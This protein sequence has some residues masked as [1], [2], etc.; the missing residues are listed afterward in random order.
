[1]PTLDR[2]LL[3]T[4]LIAA[5]L[6]VLSFGVVAQ[7]GDDGQQAKTILQKADEIRFPTQGFEVAVKIV[8]AEGGNPG[9]TRAFKVLSKGN[10]NTIV[11]TTE[12][13][14]ERG[15]ILLMKGRDLWLFVPNVSQPVRLSL[16]QRLTG[17]VANG[18]IARANFAGDYNPKVIGQE[19]IDGESHHVLELTAVDRNVTYQKVKYWVRQGN[20]Q[21]YKAEFYSMSDRLIKTC[22][23]ESFKQMSGKLRPARLVMIDALKADN[24]SVMEYE[25]MKTRDLPEKIFTKEY[26]KKLE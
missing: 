6:M 12:P 1:M 10:E 15:Q 5:A 20:N 14:A 2:R 4:T 19:Q 3:S 7:S 16:A 24:R 25:D 11:M 17:V 18:D 22:M 23:Y 8:S 21:P 26:L 9:E 13:A